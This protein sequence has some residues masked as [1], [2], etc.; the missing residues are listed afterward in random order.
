MDETISKPIA[1]LLVSSLLAILA[2]GNN[3]TSDFEVMWGDSTH[4][5]VANNGSLLM[6]TL[7]EASGANLQSYDLYQ[8]GRLD[9]LVKFVPHNSQGTIT[10]FYLS[11]NGTKQDEIDFEFLGNYGNKEYVVHT[12]VWTGGVGGREQQFHLWF[13]PRANFHNYSILWNPLNIIWYVDGTPVRVFKNYTLKGAEYPALPMRTIVSLWNGDSWATDDGKTKIDWSQAP[14]RSWYANYSASDCLV[15]NSTMSHLS[16]NCSSYP[17]F[18]KTLSSDEMKNL[19]WVQNNYMIKN[20]CNDTDT[21]PNG[22][23]PECYLS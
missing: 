8:Y 22:F 6:L 1:F 2:Q 14:F 15:S 23:P 17:W 21:Y 13:D 11:S 9:M 19:T 20:Y 12:N 16:S 7:D 5:T 3:F 4:A 10:T 18:N